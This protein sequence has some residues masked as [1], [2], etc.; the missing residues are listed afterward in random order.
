MRALNKFL[1]DK[2]Y[3]ANQIRFVEMVIEY[4]A[5]NG[6]IDPGRIYDSPFISIAP[7]GPELLYSPSDAD[8]FFEIVKHFYDTAD[9]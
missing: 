2:R 5:D 7:Q 1:D 9:V 3:S 4:L 8:E 6:T